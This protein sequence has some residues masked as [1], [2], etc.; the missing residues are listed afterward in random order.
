M[1]VTGTRN[2]YE[3]YGLNGL[4]V[5]VARKEYPLVRDYAIVIGRKE[6][7]LKIKSSV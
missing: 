6:C 5:L 7:S 2:K 3:G 4:H 1:L